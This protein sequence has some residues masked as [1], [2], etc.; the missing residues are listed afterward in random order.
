MIEMYRR[1][2]AEAGAKL[3]IVDW[4]E[5]ILHA[6]KYLPFAEESTPQYVEEM[7]GHRRW[8]RCGLR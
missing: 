5:A 2:F 3:G 4:D 1:L 7:R 8:R 6:H